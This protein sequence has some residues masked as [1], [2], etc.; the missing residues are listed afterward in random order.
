[1]QSWVYLTLPEVKHTQEPVNQLPRNLL[2][3][4]HHWRKKKKREKK[5]TFLFSYT[6]PNTPVE[7]SRELEAS[8]MLFTSY[9]E[10]CSN[11]LL[12]PH[13][14]TKFDNTA[15]KPRSLWKLHFTLWRIREEC[16]WLNKILWG[17]LLRF[18]M[19]TSYDFLDSTVH[20]AKDMLLFIQGIFNSTLSVFN[21]LLFMMWPSGYTCF[22]FIYAKIIQ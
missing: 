14:R 19:K 2:C 18:T 15:K 4:C 10:K 11:L 13:L 9:R 22:F 12:T 1:M 3:V 8:W 5:C 7:F 16:Q 21:T 20:T 17:I 6:T